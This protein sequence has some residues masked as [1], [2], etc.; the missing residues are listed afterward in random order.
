MGNLKILL[1]DLDGTLLRNDKTVSEY[2]LEILSKCKECGHFIGI[3]TS[4]SEQNCLSFLKEV[5]PDILIS[6]GG[7]LVRV[8]GTMIRCVSFSPQETKSFIEDEN[9][10][11]KFGTILYM[12]KPDE[13]PEFPNDKEN[14]Y[15]WLMQ[16]DDGNRIDLH[17]ESVEHAKKHIGD[18][19]LCKVLLD[20][21]SIL[22]EIPEATD[23]D[24]HVKKP[25]QIQFNSCTNEF[26]WCSNN[27][28][29]GLWRE[30]MPYVQDMTNFV[31]RKQLEKMLSWKAG[32]LT[33]FQISVGKSAKY[34]YKWLE[35]DE[36]QAY[37]NTYFGG[38]VAEAWAAVL[39]MCDLFEQTAVYVGN[40]LGYAYHAAEGKAARRFLE[41]VRN[42]PK[43]AKDIYL[44]IKK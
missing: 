30:E 35:A 7:A 23:K 33:N 39:H 28:A 34:L 40:R 36:Y 10:I 44:E 8:N 19:K 43:D 21:Q 12:Q 14:F 6:S 4:R 13:N 5:K 42:L 2:S 27:I 29:K 16:F 32:L 18:D 26:W 20:K 1:F 24:Y 41:H 15:G 11:C 3:S 22:P 38:N 37:L 25:S 31:V 9:W 17:V